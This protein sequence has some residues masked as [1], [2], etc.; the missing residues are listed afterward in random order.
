MNTKFVSKGNNVL[1]VEDEASLHDIIKLNLEIEG[2]K[3]ISA[4]N[5]L[6]AME[7]FIKSTI[8]C[9]ILDVM[10][11]QMDGFEVCK[12][13]REKDT[14]CPIIFLTAR[15]T[16]EEKIKGLEIGA[17]DYVTKPFHFKELLLRINKLISKAQLIE[18]TEQK[19]NHSYTIGGSEIDFDSYRVTNS[20][21][22]VF[23]LTERQI[24]MLAL[25]IEKKNQVVSRSEI[26]QKVWKFDIVP[27]TRT[28]DNVILLYRKIFEEN[29]GELYFKSIRGVGYM[30]QEK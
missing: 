13:I 5:G 22:I 19:S 21:G 30:Y 17:D 24:N 12:L 26:L 29:T 6:E 9:V 18:D 2:F 8:A 3:V 28:I 16:I 15:G 4:Y 23:D 11:P 27:N 20:Q 7:L 10:M 25:L 14:T 1:L